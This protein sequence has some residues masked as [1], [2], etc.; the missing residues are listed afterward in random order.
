[1]K[2]TNA[3]EKALQQKISQELRDIVD[4]FT[5]EVTKMSDKYGGGSMWYYFRKNNNLQSKTQF[6]VQGI[7]MV[8]SVLHRMLME[9]HGSRMLEYKS[10]ELL[11]KLSLEL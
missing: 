8:N 6:E 3:I 11:N 7:N 10:K 9:N 2:T 1:M 4:R 5:N